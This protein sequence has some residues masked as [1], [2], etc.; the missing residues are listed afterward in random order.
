MMLASYVEECRECRLMATNG[1]SGHVAGTS[2]PPPRADIHWPM[3]GFVL[4]SS[5][6]PPTG[7]IRWPMSVIV[8]ISSALPPGTDVA[9][10][11]RESPKMTQRV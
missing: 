1:L 4:F 3:S 2:A 6:Y 7:N 11:G 8:P 10:V 9:A 5:A